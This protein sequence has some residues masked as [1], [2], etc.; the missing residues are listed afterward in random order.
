MLSGKS[1][2]EESFSQKPFNPIGQ[3]IAGLK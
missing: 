3:K 2:A 1:K